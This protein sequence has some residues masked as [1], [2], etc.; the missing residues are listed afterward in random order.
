MDA[1]REFSIRDEAPGDFAAVRQVIVAAFKSRVEADLVD[2]LRAQGKIA[3]SLVATLGSVVAGH[4][5]LTD[6]TLR[7]PGLVPRGAALAPLAVRPAMQRRGIGSDLARAAI[8]RAY[9][10]GYGFMVVLGDPAYYRRFGFAPA[11]AL[12]LAC[13]F[14]APPEAFM[15]LELAPGALAGTGGLV[16]YEPEFDAV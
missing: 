1:P 15:A 4:I 6:V 11:R 16:Y 8:A 2:L 7:G 10:A 5:L 13:E 9:E 3:A 12:G 14:D